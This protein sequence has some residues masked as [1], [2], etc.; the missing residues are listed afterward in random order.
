MAH[1][2]LDRHLRAG[3]VGD[4]FPLSA[5]LITI[6]V[7]RSNSGIVIQVEDTGPGF[8]NLN[9]ALDP[10]YTTQPEEKGTGLGLSIC[11]GIAKRRGGDLRIE[12]VK[13]QGARVTLEVPVSEPHS[14]AFLAASARA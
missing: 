12:T 5:K 9:R 10:F 7:H 2:G 13:P 11:H 1:S 6:R 3:Y 14:N 4:C 8:S